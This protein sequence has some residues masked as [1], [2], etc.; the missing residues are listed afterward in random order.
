M[1]EGAS[2]L[3]VGDPDKL[4]GFKRLDAFVHRIESHVQPEANLPAAIAHE[5]KISKSIGGRTVFDDRHARKPGAGGQMS[6][7]GK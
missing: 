2:V 6:L 7:F 5:K 1:G 3:R 4:E